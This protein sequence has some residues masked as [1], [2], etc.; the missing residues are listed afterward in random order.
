LR[1]ISRMC[2]ECL[3]I[4]PDDSEP[5]WRAANGPQVHPDAHL[6]RFL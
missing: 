5:D 3:A 1:A 6:S 2:D 4:A